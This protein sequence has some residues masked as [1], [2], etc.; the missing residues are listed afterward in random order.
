MPCYKTHLQNS[1]NKNLPFCKI[2]V[3]FK[4]TTRL[5]KF[6]R[7]TDKEPFNLRSNVV[8]IFLHGRCSTT[9]YSKTSWHLNI[10]AG[11]HSGILPLPEKKSKAKTITAIKDH[12]LLSDHI[13][14]L[15]DF[16][17]LANSNS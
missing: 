1:I 13:V 12:M 17:I 15:K 9:Y 4:F 6:F 5:S 11:E 2:K 16:K 3:I 14:S 10:I 7:S 8:Y